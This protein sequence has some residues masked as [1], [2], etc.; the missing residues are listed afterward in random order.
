MYKDK[1]DGIISNEDYI[2]FRQSLNNE[3]HEIS[4]HINSINQQIAECRER[5][6][7]TEDQKAVIDKYTHFN[8]L[9][10]TV[11]DEFIDYIEIGMTSENAEPSTSGMERNSAIVALYM[12][13][14][15]MP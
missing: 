7:N 5:K 15:T 1:L 14:R 10:R 13:W 4:E 6:K 12:G 2:L 11:A 3:E 8:E 9:D